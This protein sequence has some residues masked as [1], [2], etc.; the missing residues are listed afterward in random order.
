MRGRRCEAQ[1]QLL[2]GQRCI[3]TAGSQRPLL[4]LRRALHHKGA[5]AAVHHATACVVLVQ[6]LS[7][8]L[9]NG[10]LCMT[11]HSTCIVGGPRTCSDKQAA[12]Q[13]HQV[14]PVHQLD[15]S[16]Q[17]QSQGSWCVDSRLAADGAQRMATAPH[18]ALL[19]CVD[20]AGLHRPHAARHL[21]QLLDLLHTLRGWWGWP[22]QV[23]VL[24]RRKRHRCRTAQAEKGHVL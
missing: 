15:A 9:V 3:V 6:H 24:H 19:T 12:T 14:T 20:D 16:Q 7:H 5:A 13:L 11:Q 18:C 23:G 1:L 2:S 4:L 10:S 22:L 8:G 17:G 21:H